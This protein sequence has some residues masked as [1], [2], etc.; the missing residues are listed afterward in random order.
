MSD[1][2]SGRA[3]VAATVAAAV[4]A[5]GGP[6]LAAPDGEAFYQPPAFAAGEHGD[7][8]WSAPL[9]GVAALADAAVNERVL[10]RSESV[11][12]EPIAVSGIIALPRTPAPGH[13]VVSWAHGTLG[14]ADLC[15]PSRD[16]AESP[17]HPFNADPQPVLNALLR[18]GYAVVMTDY[19][20]LGTPGP[21]PY[22]LGESEA[23]GVLDIVRAARALHPELSARFATFGHSQGGQAA[24]FAA[25]HAPTWTPEL[26]LVTAVATAPANNIAAGFQ[27]SL[28]APV[29][30][31]G[32]AFHPLFVTGAVA[33][34]P[35]I[36]PRAIFTDRAYELY[37]RDTESRCRVGLS[38]PDSWGGIRGTEIVRPEALGGPDFAK[39]IARLT[40]TQPAL[41]IAAPVRVV[42]GADDPRVNP[43]GTAALVAQLRAINGPDRITEVTYEQSAPNPISPHFGVLHTDTDPL[44]AWL[45]ERFD[46]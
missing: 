12:G 45:A 35:G 28:L 21:H 14:S 17:A 16:T 9:T 32:F 13:P 44:L 37:L 27:A 10:Y 4:F 26:E 33:A 42:Q 8:I 31:E 6:A 41:P 43:A 2:T 30:N 3:A 1:S 18:A 19:E 46:A 7:P 34:D 23:R 15:A 24:L 11:H 25:H 40:A 36:D 39:L 5:A 29:T 20:G 38:E 22:L